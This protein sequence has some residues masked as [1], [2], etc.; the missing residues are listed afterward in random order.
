[1]LATFAGRGWGGSGNDED[2]GID[3]GGEASRPCCSNVMHTTPIA[4]LLKL[5]SLFGMSVLVLCAG[6]GWG[7]FGGDED[8][9]GDGGGDGD[10]GGIWDLAKDFFGSDS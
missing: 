10:G 9:G 6:G 2:L 5:I 8:L 4:S 3:W 1:M 7:G